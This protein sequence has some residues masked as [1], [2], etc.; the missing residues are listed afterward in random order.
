MNNI[1][2]SKKNEVT[3]NILYIYIFL[4]FKYP[5]L[6]KAATRKHKNNIRKKIM[7]KISLD[8]IPGTLI[9]D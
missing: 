2:F 5:I 1:L 9:I 3:S 4:F 6:E 8:N 7:K